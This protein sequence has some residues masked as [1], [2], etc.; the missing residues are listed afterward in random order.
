M[1]SIS[2]MD[3]R[4]L[5]NNLK[6]KQ[7]DLAK[8]AKVP[9]SELSKCERGLVI[10]ESKFFASVAKVLSASPNELLQTHSEL[11][12]NPIS[13]EGYITKKN[14]RSFVM[15]RKKDPEKNAL[16]IFDIFCGTG[17][18]SHGFEQTGRFQVI[19]GLDLLQDRI[20]TF[21]FN[22]PTAKSYCYDIFDFSISELKKD[23]APEVVIG[24]PPCQGFSSI[25]PFRSV[26]ENDARN[27]LFEYFALAVKELKPKW[28][29]LE[30]VVGLLN[31]P[32]WKN[33][34]NVF[35]PYLMK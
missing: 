10:P 8:R 16:P 12:N 17:G 21:S 34:K 31:A 32:K 29:V 4:S 6:I 1:K 24:G 2:G 23:I 27:N 30:N 19:G 20:E 25:R 3:I 22:H 5:R 11:Y 14:K 7:K 26:S 9:Y 35:V 33:H 28:F 15:D 13:G 18:F